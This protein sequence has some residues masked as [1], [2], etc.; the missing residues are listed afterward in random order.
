MPLVVL[1][2]VRRKRVLATK[3]DEED[4]RLENLQGAAPPT[5]GRRLLVAVEE[6]GECIYRQGISAKVGG[7]YAQPQHGGASVA[8]H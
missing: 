1:D 5:G 2:A 7:P 3:V 8:H 4:R 6:G